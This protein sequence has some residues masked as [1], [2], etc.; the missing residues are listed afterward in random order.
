MR[1]GGAE[2]FRR[3]V[4][5]ALGAPRV[6]LV[7]VGGGEDDVVVEDLGGSLIEDVSA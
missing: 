5:G 3:G 7:V 1:V 2:V 4:I 6:G